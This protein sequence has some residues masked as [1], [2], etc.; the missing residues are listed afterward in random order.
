M[1]W[2]RLSILAAA[3]TDLHIPHVKKLENKCSKFSQSCNARTGA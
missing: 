2:G 1:S 3:I